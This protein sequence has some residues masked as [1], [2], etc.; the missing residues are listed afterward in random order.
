MQSTVL[1]TKGISFRGCRVEKRTFSYLFFPY[2]L[3]RGCT[4]HQHGYRKTRYRAAYK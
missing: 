3:D 2:K 1:R 4:R